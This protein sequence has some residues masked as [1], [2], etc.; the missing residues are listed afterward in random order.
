M[1]VPVLVPAKA[2]RPARAAIASAATV[3]AGDGEA[4]TRQSRNPAPS[5]TSAAPA[6]I[7]AR[8]AVATQVRCPISPPTLPLILLQQY[9]FIVSVGQAATPSSALMRSPTALT[10]SLLVEKPQ[11]ALRDQRR[12]LVDD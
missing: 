6:T 11:R 10:E 3:S 9:H 7:T 12:L 2:W 4:P 1:R 5:R 8:Q